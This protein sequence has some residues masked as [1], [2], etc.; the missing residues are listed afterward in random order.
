MKHLHIILVAIAAIICAAS[1]QKPS[2]D[3]TQKER[4]SFG[5][6]SVILYFGDA[7]AAPVSV[8]VTI[9][10]SSG[11]KKAYDVEANTLGAKFTSSNPNVVTIDD[12]GVFVPVGVGTAEIS[13][14]CD[15]ARVMDE[16]LSVTVMSA[17]DMHTFNQDLSQPLT[18]DMVFWQE[19][20]PGAI[21]C[22]DIDR[23]GNVYI[24]WDQDEKMHVQMF[25]AT[26][27]ISGKEMILPVSAHGDAFSIEQDKD[28]VFFWTSGSLGEPNGGFSGQTPNDSAV[29]L[30]CRF[31]FEPGTTKYTEDAESC[32]YVN[33]SG[34]RYIDIDTEHGH[35]AAT[36]K[37]V[38]YVW[39]IS[40]MNKAPIVTKT[41]TRTTVGG[42]TKIEV[43]D[44]TKISPVVQRAY[45]QVELTGNVV[46][47][48]STRAIQGFC[49]YDDRVYFT[50]GFKEDSAQLISVIDFEG[51][52]IE[53]QKP[54]GFSTSS[55]LI[56]SI[57][58][59]TAGTIES[60]GVHIHR[61]VMYCGVNGASKNESIIRL[62]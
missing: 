56:K 35:L 21:Q 25:D 47:S 29:R 30:I 20:M 38:L 13:I 53:R 50:A 6:T 45:S 40:D 27:K 58:L 16:T 4:L 26:H 23:N 24:S 19:A 34:C 8:P 5:S 52:V 28:E 33:D 46:N 57:G 39:N 55:S 62:K 32:Y 11:I 44:L 49:L 15:N 12:K 36:S 43:H 48:T 54:L 22:F 42:G 51:R 7:T 14:S 37:S 2:T 10:T 60:E 9:K 3:N 17:G 31:K 61:G 18:K 1:C 41:V 59:S